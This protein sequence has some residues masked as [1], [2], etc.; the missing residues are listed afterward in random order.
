ME[1]FTGIGKIRSIVEILLLIYILCIIRRA[2]IRNYAI[3]YE[4]NEP[5][6]VITDRENDEFTEVFEDNLIANAGGPLVRGTKE[7]E[8][9]A[10]APAA[11]PKQEV[12]LEEIRDLLKN[13]A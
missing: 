3:I 5:K 10:A 7:Q 2:V 11:P 1:R 6:E 4:N 8:A 12:L 9:E 13:K